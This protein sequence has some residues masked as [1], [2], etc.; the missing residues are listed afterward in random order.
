MTTALGKVLDVAAEIAKIKGV[1]SACAV[2]GAYDIIAMFE[3]E[4][5][6]DVADV[7]VK[8]IHSIEGVCST[9]TAICVSCK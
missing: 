1:K 5:L 6:T 4:N 9:Q 2:T 8:G 3:V 7:V